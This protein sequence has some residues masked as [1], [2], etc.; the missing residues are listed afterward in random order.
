MIPYQ[1]R[2]PLHVLQ[3]H[4]IFCLMYSVCHFPVVRLLTVGY[5]SVCNGLLGCC[6]G[7]GWFSV[8]EEGALPINQNCCRNAPGSVVVS[9]PGLCTAQMGLFLCPQPWVAWMPSPALWSALELL[10]SSCPGASIVPCISAQ[11]NVG[12]HSCP[13]LEL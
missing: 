6:M 11:H 10:K 9:M 5:F 7:N 12:Y 13:R 1:I 4:G 2:L 8:R 3:N